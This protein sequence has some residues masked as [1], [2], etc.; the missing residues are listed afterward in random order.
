MIGIFYG[1]QIVSYLTARKKGGNLVS[2]NILCLTAHCF[3]ESTYPLVPALNLML[4]NSVTLKYGL[5]IFTHVVEI[6]P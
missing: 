6:F 2:T 3:T 4:R 1:N 5:F